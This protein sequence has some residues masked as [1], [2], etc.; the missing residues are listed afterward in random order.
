M[1]QS[2]WGD[3]NGQLNALDLGERRLHALLDEYGD[4]T[5][6]AALAAL[7]VARRS[8]DARQHRGAAGRHLCL[9]RLPRQRRRHR[10]AAS[11]RARS[12]HRRRPHAAR[13]LALGAAV[14]R[15]AQHRAFDHGRVLLRRAQAS[16][17]RRARQCGL[18]RADRIR[19][20]RH[21]AARGLG[22]APGR[23]LHR[24]H[25]ARHRRDLRR[26]RQ[27]RARARQRQPVRDHQ[28]ALARRL[29]RARPALGHVLLLR[30][31]PW[32][33]PGERR[34]QSRQQSDLDRDHPAGRNPGIALS[35]HVH[36]MGAAAGLRRPGPASRRPRRDLRDRGAGR[37]RRRGV[38]A[39]RARQVSAVRRQ[40][41]QAGGAQSLRLRDRPGRERHRRSSPRSPTSRFAAARRC[42]WRR[43]AA[44]AS[45]IRTT[46]EPERVVRD[47]RLGYVSRDAAR[48]DYKVVLRAD[49]SLDA[50]ATAKARAG[51]R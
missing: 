39:R 44:A 33:Q 7:L 10:H 5:I 46:R 17:H 50:D 35:G 20:S 22:A 38:P 40:R 26:L 8:A 48:R 4:E 25:P 45:A 51:H 18:P 21:D 3:L 24:D 30:R 12:H 37:R 34:A 2:N 43:R 31:R 47:V 16:L 13:L 14:R 1:P 36:A 32:R 9:R 11:H 49:G 15:P 23:R 42:G 19:H 29:A 28:C 6:T 41:R 27:G